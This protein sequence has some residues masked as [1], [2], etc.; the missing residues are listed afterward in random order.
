M[1]NDVEL[2]CMEDT[3]TSVLTMIRNVK[4]TA[5]PAPKEE[6]ASAV[7][8]RYLCWAIS[9]N[10]MPVPPTSAIQG[11]AIVFD[12]QRGSWDEE[13]ANVVIY[14]NYLVVH[15]EDMEES[16]YRAAAII[17][18]DLDGFTGQGPRVFGTPCPSP[19]W[20]SLDH[21]LLGKQ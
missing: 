7:F 17:V 11:G 13:G 2:K 20:R 4:E 12:F 10:G 19:T 1:L 21:H 3:L 6:S 16:F 9:W 5:R 18:D 15:A 8:M 14:P